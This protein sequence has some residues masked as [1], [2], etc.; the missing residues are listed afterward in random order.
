M[1][2]ARDTGEQLIRE[3]LPELADAI[4]APVNPRAFAAEL[5]D[6]SIETLFGRL[7]GRPGLDR[8]SRSLVTIGILIGGGAADELAFHMK[9]ALRNGVTRTELEEIVYHASGYA[10]FLAAS[11][12]RQAGIRALD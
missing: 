2:E 10:G 8:H 6:M 9:A 4:T 12:A 11:Q 5:P 1:S 7:W 3:M